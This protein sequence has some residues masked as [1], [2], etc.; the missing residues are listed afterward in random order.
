MTKEPPADL[1]VSGT[2]ICKIEGPV[3][4]T[5]DSKY[6]PGPPEFD[7]AA[8]GLSDVTSSGTQVECDTAEILNALAKGAVKLRFTM[9]G[10]TVSVIPTITKIDY[11]YVCYAF[12]RNGSEFWAFE[13]MFAP[14][15]FTALAFELTIAT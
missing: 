12:L 9:D 10:Q 14:S 3:V 7:L 6:I 1:T 5:L 11:Q 4:Q 2:Y 15:V 8:M 13:F